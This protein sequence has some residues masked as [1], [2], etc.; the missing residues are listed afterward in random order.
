[1]NS[2]DSPAV[3]SNRANTPV[4]SIFAQAD[5]ISS[6]T[7]VLKKSNLKYEEIWEEKDPGIEFSHGLTKQTMMS[8]SVR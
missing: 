3:Q 1:M 6:P 7:K 2:Q 8:S 4:I 5:K